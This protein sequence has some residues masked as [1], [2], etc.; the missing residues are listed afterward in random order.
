MGS[1][2]GS[3]KIKAGAAEPPLSAASTRSVTYQAVGIVKLAQAEWVDLT[4]P[5]KLMGSTGATNKNLR[6]GAAPTRTA[7]PRLRRNRTGA[8]KEK[9]KD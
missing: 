5:M 6:S 3:R 1:E 8:E 4:K 7:M 2:E 9:G